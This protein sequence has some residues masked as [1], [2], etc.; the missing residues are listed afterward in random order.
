MKI[1]AKNIATSILAIAFLTAC[2]GGR[3][4]QAVVI[5]PAPGSKQPASDPGPQ[6]QGQGQQQPG[7]QQPGGQQPGGQ[8]QEQEQAN[9]G[10]QGQ[11][12]DGAKPQTDGSQPSTP[13]T[14]GGGNGNGNNGGSGNGTTDLSIEAVLDDGVSGGAIPPAVTPGT[15]TVGTWDGKSFKGSGKWK[16]DPVN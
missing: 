3:S 11:V 16:V 15:T 7:G 1:S 8:Q 10:D 14:Q 9:P 6:D 5:E 13:D 12:P 2:S 4:K